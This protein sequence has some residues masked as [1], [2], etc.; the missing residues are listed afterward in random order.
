MNKKALSLVAV[1]S[2]FFTSLGFAQN[3]P[4][5]TVPVQTI[6]GAESAIPLGELVDLSLSPIVNRPANL[7]GVDA[8]WAVI[9][10]AV[11][12]DGQIKLTGKRIREANDGVFFGA[13]IK[14][15][16][17]FVNCTIVYLFIDRDKDGKVTNVS[18]RTAILSK[19]IKIGEDT[20]DPV[21]PPKPPVPPTPSFPIG[22]Y[23]LSSQIYNLALSKVSD[24][25]A[26]SKGAAAYTASYSASASKFVSVASP[27]EDSLKACTAD[28]ATAL[29]NAGVSASAWSSFGDSLEDI[30]FQLYQTK[31]ITTSK[32][33]GVALQEISVGLSA[34]K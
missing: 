34:V 23:N 30:L 25:T 9:D 7:A 16:V 33:L 24:A 11:G 4:S 6:Q 26:R 13:G 14:N 8:K 29:K 1:I 28:G 31:K 18:T 2:L 20:P 12:T 3:P 17:L 22:T 19:Q 21:V 5:V 32:D 15:K 10:A 27:L